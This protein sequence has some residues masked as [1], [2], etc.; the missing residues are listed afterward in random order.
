[1]YIWDQKLAGSSQQPAM[2]FFTY[3]SCVAG[4]TGVHHRTHLFIG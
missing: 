4:M 3:I 1:M 2:I